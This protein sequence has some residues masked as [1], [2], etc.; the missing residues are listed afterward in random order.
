MQEVP[1][2]AL[3]V[4]KNGPKLKDTNPDADPTAQFGPRGRT[5]HMTMPKAA[6]A[7]LV[8]ALYQSTLLESSRGGQ[9]GTDGYL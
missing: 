1:V 8:E 5:Y 7:D 9:N 4:G 3:V 2:C 6:M